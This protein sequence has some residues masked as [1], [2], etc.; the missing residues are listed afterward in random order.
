MPTYLYECKEH[1]EFE[2]EQSIKADPLDKCPEC[3]K[4]GKT[5]EAPKK[6]MVPS[7]FIL[8]GGSWAKQ[9]YK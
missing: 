2:C 5:S 4:E 6:L 9:G 1:G 3:E 8:K 7:S